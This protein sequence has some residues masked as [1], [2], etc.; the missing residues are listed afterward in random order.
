ME[1]L[2]QLISEIAAR[3]SVLTVSQ[4]LAIG[5]CTVLA[6]FSMLWLMQ[7]STL[8]DTVS[9]LNHDFSYSELDGAEE[10]LKANDIPYEIRGTRV[11]RSRGPAQCLACPS[12]R[13]RA[14]RRQPVRHGVGGERSEPLR[15][16]G[17]GD[18]AQNYAKGNELAKIIATTP[19]VKQAS[20]II[21]PKSKRRLGGSRT[22]PLPRSR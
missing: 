20:V 14:S 8:P 9:L 4:R 7:W 13:Q 19:S 10:A 16:P 18:Y 1:R 11:R 17:G 12:R 3:L 22:F 2:R 21:N 6:A 5:L 15:G